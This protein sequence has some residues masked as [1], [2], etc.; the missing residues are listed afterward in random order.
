MPSATTP[1]PSD[2]EALRA[3]AVSLREALA[4]RERELA[5]RDA[6]LHAKT[7]HIEKLRAT[8]ALM[9]RVR[10]GRSSEKIDQLEL[11]IGE[12]EE[13]AAEEQARA[14]AGSPAQ[15]RRS[16]KTDAPRPRGRQPLPAHLPRERVVHDAAC[17]CPA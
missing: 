17:V 3:L 16:S 14:T 4:S 1:L 6:E 10:F 5:A 15:D 11:L 9:K 2:R 13:A 7:L 12:L 8:L